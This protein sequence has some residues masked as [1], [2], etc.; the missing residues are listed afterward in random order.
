MKK[1]N[2]RK[3][4]LPFIFIGVLTVM[5]AM[6]FL[7]EHKV[8]SENEKRVLAVLPEFSWKKVISGEFQDELETFISD[9]IPG[10]DFFVGADAYFSDVM[11]RNALGKIYRGKDGYLI[12][13]PLDKVTEDG[14]NHFEKNISNFES[15]SL[16]GNLKS[17]LVIVPSAG[18]IMEDKLPSFHKPYNDAQLLKR[19]EELAPS[20]KLL[21]VT[22]ALKEAYN[23]GEQVYYRTDHHLTSRG[24][25]EVY[26]EFCNLNDMDFPADKEYKVTKYKDFYGTTYSGS[27]YWFTKP[28]ELETWD[29]GEK[30]TV[31]LEEDGDVYDKVFFEKYLDRKDKYPVYL[32]GNHSFV[33]IENPDAKGGNLL[34]IRDSFGQNFAPFIAHNYKTVY[35][36][37]MR[38]Y[39]NSIAL[40]MENAKIDE[41]MYLYGIDTLLT[42]S[43]TSY[44]FF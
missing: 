40:L 41:V 43:S 11:G 12:N 31:T 5:C 38:Y 1:F 34:V 13:A 32:D 27:G 8:Y 20:V 29:F 28:D 19:A 17:T 30:L 44:L 4:L 21:D 37:D 7:G 6:T 42:D 9:H 3:M 10:R 39:R 26:K 2:V 14:T 24:S 15:F 18:Y 35:M 22:A 36:L 23:E 25:Y 16:F 33:K